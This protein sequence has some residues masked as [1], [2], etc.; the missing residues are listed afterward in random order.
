MPQVYRAGAP[1]EWVC[2]LGPMVGEIHRRLGLA[3]S[4]WR[5]DNDQAGLCELL[6][7]ILDCP[8]QIVRR[9]PGEQLRKSAG[10][11]GSRLQPPAQLVEPSLGLGL[12]VL[13]VCRQICWVGIWKEV[14]V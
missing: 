7:D 9:K 10:P 11:A 3:L 1:L 2:G 13:V 4:H 14:G 12:G 5:L 6:R 8:L